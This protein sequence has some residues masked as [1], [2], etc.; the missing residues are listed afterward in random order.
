MNNIILKCQYSIRSCVNVFAHKWKQN[1]GPSLFSGFGITP[2]S[3]RVFRICLGI[4]LVIYATILVPDH[5][6]FLT[7]N[8]MAPSSLMLGQD[9]STYPW[10][11]LYITNWPYFSIIF[12]VAIVV[13]GA[14]L[15]IDIAPRVAAGT[16]WLLVVSI[17]H[18][19]PLIVDF[20]DDFLAVLLLG[21]FIMPINR[22]NSW[23]RVILTG[24]TAAMIIQFCII[25]WYAGNAKDPISWNFTGNAIKDALSDPTFSTEIGNIM[26]GHIE[27]TIMLSYIVKTFESYIWALLLMPI[28]L[29]RRI[30]AVCIMLYQ[31]IVF[32]TLSLGF[33]PICSFVACLLFLDIGTNS[34]RN[35]EISDPRNSS[36][37]ST[38]AVEW[39]LPFCLIALA[40]LSCSEIKS[41]KHP[42]QSL[43]YYIGIPQQWT[44][45]A[46]APPP[47]RTP[48][49]IDVRILDPNR[50]INISSL[51]EIWNA[52]V[53]LVGLNLRAHRWNVAKM[54][55]SSQRFRVFLVP[56]GYSLVSFLRAKGAIAATEYVSEIK[57][58][59]LDNSIQ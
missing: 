39:V 15:I 14:L 47:L 26:R 52:P 40:L 48:P 54:K 13:S 44:I 31:I 27:G 35:I 21:A 33:L 29:I 45:Y 4:V 6:W 20:G 38:I 55:V 16:A 36:G 43:C 41:N 12:L 57:I 2:M 3:L 19:N 53:P 5:K 37:L 9:K 18:R 49:N 30:G 42:L 34:S 17:I 10:S 59:R 51:N 7:D 8:G 24:G 32:C 50:I 28:L 11:I 46:P 1:N 23:N 22:T 58:Q 25:Y 56:Y